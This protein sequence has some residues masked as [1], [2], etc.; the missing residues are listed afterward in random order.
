MKMVKEE[1]QKVR[2]RK[3]SV[4]EMGS[5]PH[6]TYEGSIRSKAGI[7]NR[8][9]DIPYRLVMSAVKGHS[10]EEDEEDDVVEYVARFVKDIGKLSWDN[11]FISLA[12]LTASR[13]ACSRLHVG[14]VIVKD[15]RIISVGYNGFLPG[16]PHTS[17]V[18][19]GHEQSTVHAEQNC[20]SDCAKRG[21]AV[22]GATAF[23][24]HYPCVN[25]A[26]V[27]A[28]AGIGCVK[29]YYDY[30][31]SDVVRDLFAESGVRVVKLR[32]KEV[33][34]DGYVEHGDEEK[35]VTEKERVDGE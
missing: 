32:L 29:F 34:I 15:T 11:Y 13:S 28:A 10:V 27:L 20:I 35:S 7:R 22:G 12:F 3:R 16:A 21:V 2:R 18:I 33:K 1:G 6:G 19:N 8:N 14:C 26:K 17:R 4:I 23:V 31:N 5:I 25:C 30:K 24:T 9:R